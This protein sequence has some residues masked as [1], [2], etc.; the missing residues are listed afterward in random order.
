VLASPL[1]GLNSV[2]DS[3][4]ESRKAT[5]LEEEWNRILKKSYSSK[6]LIIA[7]YDEKSGRFSNYSF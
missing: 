2:P 7:N 4:S 3:K 6:E 5:A 1:M